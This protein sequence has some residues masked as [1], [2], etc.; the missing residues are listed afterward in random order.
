MCFNCD[1][2]FCLGH[3][4]KRLFYLERCWPEED[5]EE[6]TNNDGAVEPHVEMGEETSETPLHA[7]S[8]ARAPQT[9][10]VR[11]NIGKQ[12][13]TFLVDSGSTHNFLSN[14]IA[15]KIGL[16]PS[17]EAHLE[18]A[19]A[20]GEKLASPRQCKVVYMSLQGV[21]ITMDLYL[22]PWKGVMLS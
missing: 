21:P 8:G 20:N 4:C 18:V 11:G 12:A 7:I 5:E 17:N 3:H 6:H 19:V 13:I 16:V 1:E 14:D 15:K 9:M 10:R 22:L 2:K